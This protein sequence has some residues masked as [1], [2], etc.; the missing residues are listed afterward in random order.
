MVLAQ[1]SHDGHE[2]FIYYLSKSLTSAKL[3]HTHVEKLALAVVLV[4][5]RFCHYILLRKTTIIADA[6]PMYHILTKHVLGGKYSCW[7][8]FLQE[9][10]LEFVKA[11]S[12]K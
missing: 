2:N 11:K 3:N 10:D 1:E 12:K 9:F 6:N 4:V 7:I 8:I 5:Q